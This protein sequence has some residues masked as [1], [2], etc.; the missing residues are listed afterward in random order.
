MNPASLG[1]PARFKE[2]RTSQLDAL[3]AV[4]GG[5]GAHGLNAPTGTGKTVIYMGAAALLDGRTAVLTSTKS[6]QDQLQR[7]FS[8]TVDIRG[9]SN[10]ECEIE[11]PHK[12][13]VDG[14][15]CHF[16]IKCSLKGGGCSY[17]DDYRKAIASRTVVSNYSYWLSV[18]EYAEGLGGFDLLVCDEAHNAMDE[19]G[20]HMSARVSDWEIDA[21]QERTK[22]ASD[23]PKEWGKWAEAQLRIVA[24][25]LIAEINDLRRHAQNR[26]LLRRVHEVKKLVKKLE[27]IRDIAESGERWV[28]EEDRGAMVWTPVWPGRGSYALFRGIKKVLMVSATLTPKTMDLLGLRDYQYSEYPSSIPLVNRPVY[29]LKL[30]VKLRHDVDRMDLKTWMD[31]IDQVIQFRLPWKGLIH[32]VSYA[33]RDYLLNNS[34]FRG[35]MITHQRRDA[36]AKLEAFKSAKAPAI[37]VSPSMDTGIDLPGD[38]CRWQIICKVPF[39]DSRS[40]VYAAR[41][42]DDKEYGLHVTATTIVQASGRIVRSPS[43]WGETFIVDDQI[44]WVVSK[45][46]R[47]FPQW[48]LSAY[49]PYVMVTPP[50]LGLKR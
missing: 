28:Y 18:H 41:H 19:L 35:Y 50:P 39:P 48:W 45:Y 44:E 1:L 43:D 4:A 30:G 26:S 25:K 49:R 20:N 11:K 22:P 38:Y 42:K 10:Y 37:L 7:E 24:P 8:K 47:F 29:H 17:F 40:P 16:G 5:E 6:L 21:F 23:T 32:T 2:W 33:R 34:R 9:Q 12:V 15:V 36:R 46:R 27:S 14:A 13:T 3:F 31:K